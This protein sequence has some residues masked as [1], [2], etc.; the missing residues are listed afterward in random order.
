MEKY[1]EPIPYDEK[2]ITKI[3]A[4]NIEQAKEQ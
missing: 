4:Q 2:I 3:V 1:G